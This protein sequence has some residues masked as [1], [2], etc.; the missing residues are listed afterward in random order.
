[1]NRRIFFLS[2]TLFYVL[3]TFQTYGFA[4]GGG[5]TRRRTVAVTY[6]KDPVKVILAGTTLRPTARGEA[7]VERWRKRN[8]S[9]IDITIENLIP[10]YNFG[11]DF[12]TYV[13]WAITPAGQVDNL[14]EFRLSGGTGRLKTATPHQ[15]F[16]M[17]VTAEPH[18]L[19]RLPSRMV[20]LENLTPNS[21]NVN[22]QVS[23]VYFTGDSGK[24]YSNDAAPALAERDYDKTPMELLQARRA[25]QI[26]KLADAERFDPDDYISSFN[27]LS[28]AEAAFKRGASVHDV[29][30]IARESITFA[31][32]ARDI[33]EEKALAA[34]RRAEIARRDN[35]LRRAT[36][37]ASDLQEQ[38]SDL[39]ARLKGSEIARANSDE[40]LG[41]AMRET[42]EAKVENRGLQNENDRL[43]EENARLVR[44]LNDTKMQL[45]TLQSQVAAQN[46]KINEAASRTEALER[47]EREREK[48]E[49]RRRDFVALQ[50]ALSSI[51]TVKPNGNGF[52]AILPDHF[53]VTNQSSLALKAKA[54]ID[55]LAQTLA[56]HPDV[57]FSIEG[58][59]DN[60]PNAELLASGRAQAVAEYVAASGVS[61]TNFKVESRG[62]SMPISTAKTLA[63]KAQNRRVE[64]IF[65]AP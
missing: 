35:E 52:I 36:E 59:S 62:A 44:E 28:Q 46:L 22:V 47:A 31:V 54:K 55:A 5:D 29:G 58:H 3:T 12:T 45:S 53:F 61:R 20:V 48:A 16:A 60:R 4:Q 15:T 38:V 24:Y 34:A 64:L 14:G 49:A 25:V 42:A 23:D 65:I 50:A 9:E 13:L 8:E 18:Y 63:A 1:M 57:V 32:R 26:A 2:L 33:S 51:V 19:V 7:T 21:K 43:H 6:L 30:R 27:S 41:R 11:S 39:T 17:I 10:A 40:Q 56:A 37:N